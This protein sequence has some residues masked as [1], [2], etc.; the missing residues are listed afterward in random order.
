MQPAATQ[1]NAG[2]R[3][4]LIATARALFAERGVER[5]SM[6]E[7][8]RE[9]GQGNVSAL[10]YHFGDRERLLSAV[11]ESENAEIESR[12]SA[13]LD[14]IDARGELDPRALAS[15]LVRPAAAMLT[16]EAGREHLRIVAQIVNRSDIGVRLEAMLEQ[17]PSMARWRIATEACMPREGTRLHRRYTAYQL[18]SV[19][20]GR[21]AKLGNRRD[22]RLFTSHLIDLCAA[23]V[24]AP[25]SDETKTLLSETKKRRSTRN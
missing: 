5:V 24:S 14:E 8:S 16:T 18:C 10:Q 9:A 13:L 2:T 3:T 21:R 4:K 6:R 15:A 25:I 23:I 19:E 11:L 1:G 12:R 7:I 20:L 17:S 22:Q